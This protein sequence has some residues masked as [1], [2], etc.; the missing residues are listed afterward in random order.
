M[1]KKIYWTKI[2]FKNDSYVVWMY[3]LWKFNILINLSE[4]QRV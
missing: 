4:K 3:M 2:S 1:D